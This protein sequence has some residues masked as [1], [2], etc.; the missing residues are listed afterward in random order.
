MTLTAAQGDAGGAFSADLRRSGRPGF[1]G[2][3]TCYRASPGNGPHPTIGN[4]AS[5]AV[6]NAGTRSQSRPRSRSIVTGRHASEPK[7]S[8]SG[9]ISSNSDGTHC[10]RLQDYIVLSTRTEDPRALVGGEQ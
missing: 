8:R 1:D 4:F 3:A 10:D 5:C 7:E 2:E 9:S 6:P